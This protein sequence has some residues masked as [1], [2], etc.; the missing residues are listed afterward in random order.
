MR[1]DNETLAASIEKLSGNRV[2]F[3]T[4]HYIRLGHLDQVE[5]LQK[6]AQENKCSTADLVQ[7]LIESCA[8]DI[9]NYVDIERAPLNE[10]LDDVTKSFQELFGRV[11]L[12]HYLQ[13]KFA[14]PKCK[15]YHPEQAECPIKKTTQK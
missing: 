6:Y 10:I 9:L 14:C 11:L 13:K 15:L 1:I 2:D 8:I 5:E 4:A 3:I 7:S 12:L